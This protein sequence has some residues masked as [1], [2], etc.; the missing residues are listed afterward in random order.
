MGL[1][2]LNSAQKGFLHHKLAPQP[3]KW[4][5]LAKKT[6]K[7]TPEIACSVLSGDP[8]GVASANNHSIFSKESQ[9]KL[10]GLK[11]GIIHQKMAP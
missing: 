2:N 5:E 7:I 9:V 10:L 11:R 3:Q 6:P 8:T 1:I 4:P